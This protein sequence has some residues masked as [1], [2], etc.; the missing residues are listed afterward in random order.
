MRVAE[1]I[2]DEVALSQ[3]LLQ[4]L[5]RSRVDGHEATRIRAKV[6]VR[7]MAQVQVLELS[8]QVALVH[9]LVSEWKRTPLM[10]RQAALDKTQSQEKG[11]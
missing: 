5:S 4:H 1:H 3:I 6:V 9:R 2:V 7:E 11:D 10:Q 8:A